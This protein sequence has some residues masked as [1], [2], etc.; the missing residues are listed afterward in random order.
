MES[1]IL[2]NMLNDQLDSLDVRDHKEQQ[3]KLGLELE[4]IWIYGENDD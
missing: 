2:E 3:P 1:W 4:D